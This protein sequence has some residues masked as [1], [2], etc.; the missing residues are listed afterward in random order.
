MN[1]STSNLF[2]GSQAG[3]TGAIENAP[4]NPTHIWTGDM[5][6]Q[7]ANNDMGVLRHRRE[8]RYVL[9]DGGNRN[10]CRANMNGVGCE[11]RREAVEPIFL[12]LPARPNLTGSRAHG[13]RGHL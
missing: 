2:L 7:N 11:R 5:T 8:R 6:M 1:T 13:A 12:N 4:H 9:L 10:A 3:F